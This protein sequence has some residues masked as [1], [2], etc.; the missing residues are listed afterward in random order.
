MAGSGEVVGSAER[1]GVGVVEVPGVPGLY[2]FVAAEAWDGEA[3][4][5]SLAAGGPVA[6]GE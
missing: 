4:L 3:G 1:V 6:G 5:P 2:G